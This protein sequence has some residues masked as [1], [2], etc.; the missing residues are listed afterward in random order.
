MASSKT[1]QGMQTIICGL[2]GTLANIDHRLHHLEN[3]V[4]EEFFGAV[5]DD[6]VNL[7]CHLM[8]TAMFGRGY[9]IIFVTG[10]NECTREA[11]REWLDKIGLGGCMIHM[12]KADDRR[13]DFEVKEEICDN[14]LKD[15]EILFVLEDRQQVV[16]MW[17]RKDLT[18]LQ[19]AEGSF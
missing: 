17:R 9:E 15:R 18:V 4:W 6:K 8:L 1:P 14:Y 10:R 5:V 7:W 16:D 12:R 19:C 2:D 3:Q 11:T 13:P